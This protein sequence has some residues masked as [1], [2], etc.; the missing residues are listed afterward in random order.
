MKKLF[1]LCAF[2]TAVMFVGAQN[3][4]PATASDESNGPDWR[5]TMP[6]HEFSVG[7]GDALWPA[8]TTGINPIQI[9]CWDRWDVGYPR[10]YTWFDD[11]TYHGRWWTA[12]AYS[13]SYLFRVCKFLWL[14]GEVAYSNYNSKIYDKLT[15]VQIG[16]DAVHMVSIMSKIRFSFMNSKYVT[17]YAGFS[18]GAGVQINQQKLNRVTEPV[19]VTTRWHMT[20]Q[21]TPFGVKAGKSFFGFAEI[22]FGY[23]GFGVIGFGYHF[24]AKNKDIFK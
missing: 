2:L 16:T 18:L 4:V 12:G 7:V 9:G 19:P 11:E 13:F 3:D 10:P 1:L 5:T 24:N 20:G 22:G 21:L 6:R 14:G 23:K 15:D 8:I 17:L